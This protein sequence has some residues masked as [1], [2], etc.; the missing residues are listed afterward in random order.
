MV[1][2]ELLNAISDMMDAKFDEFKMNLATKDDIANMATKDDIANMATKDDIANMATKDDIANMATKDDIANM[3]TKDDIANMA[4]KD[5]IAC[6]WK[7][8]SKLPT[9]A[10]LR[11]VENNVLTEVDRVQEIGTRHYHEVKREMSQLRAEVRS[12]QIGSLKLRVDRL[13]RMLE[14]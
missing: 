4:T 1:E 14:L 12:Y 8:I 6:I 3:A 7:V 2:K 5:D 13:E 9:K 11:E 10:D